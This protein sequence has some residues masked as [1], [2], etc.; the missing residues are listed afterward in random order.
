VIALFA[1]QI[2]V[3]PWCKKLRLSGFTAGTALGTKYR[4]LQHFAQHCAHRLV[5]VDKQDIEFGKHIPRLVMRAPRSKSK[6]PG[7]EL[8]P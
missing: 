6:R 1:V 7:R 8:R 2:V 4:S 3:S 5:V